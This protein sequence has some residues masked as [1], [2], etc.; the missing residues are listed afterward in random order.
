MMSD[1][2]PTLYRCACCNSVVTSEDKQ[3]A[4]FR[5]DIYAY[6]LDGATAYVK[7]ELRN[8]ASTGFNV[9]AIVGF[10]FIKKED[11]LL[12][13]MLKLLTTGI[14]GGGSGY[15][16]LKQHYEDQA[17]IG[18]DLDYMPVLCVNCWFKEMRLDEYGK[19][20]LVQQEPKGTDE[21]V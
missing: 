4:Q 20:K 7:S 6:R 21:L 2:S 15:L 16:T 8:A 13:S 1:V 9:G 5:K 11:N 12:V 19:V 10:A 3:I 17:R 18:W 14:I